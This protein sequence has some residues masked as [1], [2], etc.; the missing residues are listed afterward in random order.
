M[1]EAEI[2]AIAAEVAANRQP[3]ILDRGEFIVAA[4]SAVVLAIVTCVGWLIRAHYKTRMDIQELQSYGP[5]HDAHDKAAHGA[6]EHEIMAVAREMREF[7][8]ES[9]EQHGELANQVKSMA[10]DLNRLIGF[11]EAQERGK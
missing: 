11:H 6:L 8:A 3:S 10:K 7:R 1:T 9:R 4:A 5:Q 2:A